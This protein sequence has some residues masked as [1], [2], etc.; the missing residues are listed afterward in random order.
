MHRWKL[1]NR[2]TVY[3]DQWLTLYQDEVE[4]PDGNKG[5]YAWA[6]R[7][8]G[9]GIAVITPQHKILL[10]REYRYVIDGYSWELPGGGIDEGETPEQAA[11]RE[12]QEETGL[13]AQNLKKL[14]EFYPLHSF[15]S[16][17]VTIFITQMEEAA[18]TTKNSESAEQVAEQKFIDL[19]EA[20]AMID[21]GEVNDAM[22]ALVVQKVARLL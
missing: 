18:L 10:N 6:N 16:E 21:R 11:V 9:V 2:K 13:I 1:L 3:Q 4:F 8:D 22:T 19:T 7:N 5:T 14:Y 12:L 17:K 15:N 20:L